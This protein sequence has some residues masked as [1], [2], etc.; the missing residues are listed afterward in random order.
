MTVLPFAGE[1]SCGAVVAQSCLRGMVKR[2]CCDS[3][4]PQPSYSELD[5]PFDDAV[6]D[7]RLHECLIGGRGRG[8]FRR[9][10]VDGDP[11]AI[12]V[13]V[14]GSGFGPGE[15]HVGVV[16]GR[17]VLRRERRDGGAAGARIGSGDEELPRRGVGVRTSAE[18]RVD[19][20]G[21]RAGRNVGG[22]CDGAVR[23]ADVLRGGAVDF[24]PDAIT[25]RLRDGRPGEG[26]GRCE[27]AAV[28]R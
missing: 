25:D 15:A 3:V 24:D 13:G 20:R 21:D 4:D 16:Q 9:R 17:V 18:E 19:M 5:P 6:S 10:A 14:G 1:S 11:E 22:E 23:R 28:G 12:A 8:H 2:K 27:S 7:R 26:D